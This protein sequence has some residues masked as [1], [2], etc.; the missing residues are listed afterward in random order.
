MKQYRW[1]F[2]VVVFTVTLL[3]VGCGSQQ[4][5]TK[6]YVN[7]DEV[8]AGQFDN[9]KMWTF[10]FPPTE[11]FAKTYNFNP[12]KS[13]FE[14]AR[15]ATLRLPNCS[16]SFV[17]EDGLVMTN[18]HCA[19]GPLDE[20]T[21]EGERLA[22]T[23]FYAPTLDDERKVPNFYIDQLRVMEDVTA[24]VQAAFE[25]GKT[26]NQK[27][28]NRME[29][30]SEIQKRYAVKYKKSA[31]QDSM[32]F[33]VVTFYNG[34]RYSLY[35]YKR[36]TDIR[37]VYAPEEVMAFYGGDPDNFTYPRY[38][39]DCSFFRVYDNGKPLK[40]ENFFK[41][42]AAG[43]Q[44]GDAVFVVGNPGNTSRL[45]TIAQLEYLRD[46]VYPAAINGFD[47]VEK[48]YSSYIE[49]HPDAKLKYMSM[50]FGLANSRKAVTGYV[51]GLRDPVLMAK[52]KDFEKKFKAAVEAKPELKEKYGNPWSDIAKY[53]EELNSIYFETSAFSTRSRNRSQ[54]YMLTSDLVELAHAL[55]LP[56]EQR[57]AKFQ[58][59]LLDTAKAKLYPHDIVAEL[60]QQLLANQLGVMKKALAG[61][62][63]A[64][65]Q[66]LGTKSPEQAAQ[67]L[68]A[69]TVFSS[70]EKIDAMVAKSPDE[71][72]A[73]GD[74]LIQFLVA[75]REHAIAV[76]RQANEIQEKLGAR[77]QKLG[78]ALYAVYGTNIPPD[79]TFTLRIADG[80]V[81]GY[82]YN[83]TLA[84]PITTFYGM[85]DRYYSFGMKDPWKLADRWINPP[86][87]FK[88]STPM[89]FVSTNDI[90]GG[91][92]GSPIISK[93]LQVVGLIFD[94]NMESLP[95]DVIFDDAKNRSVAVHSAGI[96]EGLEQI[97]KADRIS[98]ELRN[99]KITP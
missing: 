56:A 24:E 63:E 70:K 47:K 28:A 14:R 74:P 82:E 73:S 95:G 25:S 98:K 12:D 3:F 37:I 91:N 2:L 78:E 76:R 50:I 57:P 52:K 62:N 17:S 10:D 83:G 94:G 97:Y 18:H 53:Q 45:L 29:K 77:V 35:G 9:G 46:Y 42:S 38:D 23:G 22:E 44:E 7:L 55:K 4:Q 96:L 15:L 81:K 84:P 49:K 71:I 54:Y 68:V 27:I 66:L 72:L 69:I 88:M 34:G 58:G 41:F 51:D 61:K 1:N 80:V 30:I 16:A 67:E 92:S 59:A 36:F 99:G 64:F 6:S 26:D 8:Q 60:D 33:N 48:I 86:S 85:Y 90:I 39:F 79:A 75:T 65:N 43:A 31:P 93:D 21:K 11:Y 13:W 89:N 19:R 32:M 40:T 20:V 5:A 87:T